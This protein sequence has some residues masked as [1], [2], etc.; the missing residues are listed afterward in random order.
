LGPLIFG[1]GNP[2]TPN[3]KSGHCEPEDE[4]GLPSHER[5]VGRCDVGAYQTPPG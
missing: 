3:G 5:D 2:A 1:A 4:T